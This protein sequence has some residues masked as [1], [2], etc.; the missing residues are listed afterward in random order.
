[1]EILYLSGPRAGE[2]GR[3]GWP[4]PLP[5]PQASLLNMTALRILADENLAL[6]QEVF[7]GLGSLQTMP[8]RAIL[9]EHL[10]GVD[11][12][13]VRS[14]TRVDAALLQGSSCRFVGTATSGIDHIDRIWLQ[15]QRIGFADAHGCNAEGVVD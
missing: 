12:L 13:L 11:A 4:L 15:Q 14:V 2:H 6:V 5:H 8:G 3:R 1:P 7:G 9:P 10:A